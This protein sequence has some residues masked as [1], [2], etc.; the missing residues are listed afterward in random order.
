MSTFAIVLIILIPITAILL[1]FGVFLVIKQTKLSRRTSKITELS[2]IMRLERRVKAEAVISRVEKVISGNAEYKPLFQ[3]LEHYYDEIIKSIDKTQDEYEDLLANSKTLDAKEFDSIISSVKQSIEKLDQIEIKFNRLSAQITQQDEF[4]SSEY[5]FYSSHLRES[6]EIYRK[7]RILLNKISPK[8]DSLSDEIKAK[9]IEFKEMLDNAKNAK[10]TEALR[11]YSSLV[12][13]FIRVVSESPKIETY[14][15]QTIPKVIAKLTETYKEKKAEISAPLGHINFKEQLVEMSKQFNNAK[16]AYKQLN[17]SKTKDLIRKI[18]KS[19]KGLERLLNYEIISRNFFIANYDSSIMETKQTLK[20]YVSLKGQ[21][22]SVVSKGHL[23][24][25]DLVEAMEE[26]KVFAKEVDQYA[27]S[28]REAMKDKTIPYSSKV[29][30]M[31]TLLNKNLILT[32]KM[33]DA[34]QFI[35]SINIESSILKNKFRKSEA[36]INEVLANMKKQNISL[37]NEQKE[38]YNSIAEK[39]DITS[40]ALDNQIVNKELQQQIDELMKNTTSFYKV[41]SGDIQIAEIVMNLIKELSPRRAVN[42]RL[43]IALNTAEKSYLE[44][45]YPHALNTII[46]E[47]EQGGK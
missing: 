26:I 7:K 27:L 47:L 43:N 18:L 14:I 28:Y 1:I 10:A 36:A 32:Q 17:I 45:K 6:I 13:K 41:V 11:D 9:S 2:K 33:N 15:Y 39:I 30:R 8:I 3:K 4:L 38:A 20:R 21:I 5:V 31:K 12:V 19:V 22:K 34:L 35:W 40:K 16:L 23:I 24:P 44:G 29:S 42:A 46:T 37:S 25:V